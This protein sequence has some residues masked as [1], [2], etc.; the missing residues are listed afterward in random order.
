MEC[1]QRGL[2]FFMLLA[3]PA[4]MLFS[5]GRILQTKKDPAIGR[6]QQSQLSEYSFSEGMREYVL[7]HF[8]QAQ[9]AFEKSL[10]LLPDMAAANYM[11]GRIAFQQSKNNEALNYVLKALQADPKNK[12]YYLLTAQIYERQQ[13]FSEA[14][15][16]YKRL[17]EEVSSAE[18]Y[19]YDLAASYIYQQDFDEALNTFSK[20]ETL[21][22]KS[23]ELTRQKQQLFLKI[24]KLDLALNEG[25][26]YM[27]DFPDDIDFK[28]IQA[29]ILYSNNRVDEAGKFLEQILKINPNNGDAR[30][31]L[32]EIYKSKGNTEKSNQQL[33]YIFN[34]S[35]IEVSMKISVLEDFRRNS[36]DESSQKIAAKYADILAKN[37]PGDAKAL[38]AAGDVF[39]TLN[40][41]EEAW[42]KYL[43]ASLI[44]QSD[45]NLWN[46]IILLD[47]EL[48][49]A[50]SMLLHAE[51]ALQVFPNNATFWL[52][53]GTAYLIKKDSRKAIE[54]LE[55]GLRLSAGNSDLQNEFY[56][57]LGDSYHD[58]KQYDKS[59]KAFEEALKLNS[60]NDHVLNNYSYYLS[61]RNT[62]LELA[63]DMSERL[64]KKYP[65]NASYLDTYAWVLYMLKDYENALKYL[66]LAIANSNN[67]TIFEHYGDTLY[68][69]GRKE[70]ALEQWEKA[71][72]LG[73]NSEL[74][75]K[76]IRDKTWYEQ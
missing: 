49:Q 25:N 64:I 48:N 52:F 20:I 21:F 9:S 5:C 26:V 63:K 7:D 69:L 46:K 10:S 47:S 51:A 35:E 61:L 73:E 65:S 60:S 44:E 23:P 50:D 32:L 31:L 58:V 74:L 30:L 68:Q 16:I 54:S 13:N 33:D 14:S 53:D 28:I 56:I 66:E 55:Q 75:D 29:E 57:R 15:K 62:K 24:N 18:D 2:Y 4:S 67:G 6:R 42:K 19:Y 71:K 8:P 11:L 39:L 3:V 17:I 76:K 40:N 22:G 12:Y 38:V 59:D 36:S 72:Q 37:N 41:K 43:K 34:N 27:A 70:N 45:F 1:L